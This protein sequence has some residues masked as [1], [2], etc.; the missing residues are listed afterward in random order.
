MAMT[1]DNNESSIIHIGSSSFQIFNNTLLDAIQKRNP[2]LSDEEVREITD[3]VLQEMASRLS[4]GEDLAFLRASA[5]GSIDFSVINFQFR[6]RTP[7]RKLLLPQSND[8][9]L[10]EDE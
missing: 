1:K 10:N 4:Q 5:D 8:D 9:K 3:R 6:P 7:P 2:H